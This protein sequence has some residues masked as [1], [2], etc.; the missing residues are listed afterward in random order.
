MAV[1]TENIQIRVD[2]AREAERDLDGVGRAFDGLGGHIA[3]AA[4]GLLTFQTAMKA[5]E[6]AKAGA[7][8]EQVD[9]AFVALGGTAEQAEAAF[10][11]LGG[12]V[13]RDTIKRMANTAKSLGI[14]SDQFTQLTKVALA[15]SKALGRDVKTSLEDIVT[16]TARYS[17]EILD[18]LALKVSVG[19]ANENYARKL[20]KTVGQLSEAEKQQAFF[21]E[22][23]AAGEKLIDRVGD[24]VEGAAGAFSVLSAATDE[25]TGNVSRFLAGLGEDAIAAWVDLVGDAAVSVGLISE[26]TLSALRGVASF[27]KSAVEAA[28]RGSE[29]DAARARANIARLED[30]LGLRNAATESAAALRHQLVEQR[31]A[32]LL[33]SRAF[34]DL[35]DLKRQLP[36]LDRRAAEAAAERQLLAEAEADWQAA[37]ADEAERRARAERAAAAAAKKAAAAAARSAAERRRDARSALDFAVG[38]G[39]R[40][41][42]PALQRDPVAEI[43]KVTERIGAEGARAAERDRSARVEGIGAEIDMTRDLIDIER[44]YREGQLAT[45]GIA[46]MQAAAFARVGTEVDETGI[47]VK[48]FSAILGTTALQAVGA[49]TD[50]MGQWAAQ[51]LLTGDANVKALG[52]SLIAAGSQAIGMGISGLLMAPIVSIFSPGVGAGMAAASAAAIAGGAALAGI[53]KS[54]GGTVRGIDAGGNATGGGASS[55]AAEQ[56]RQRDFRRSRTGEDRETVIVINN[57]IGGERVDRQIHRAAVRGAR[58][59]RPRRAG[60][61]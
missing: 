55:R 47:K 13:D 56:D 30:E 1:T 44:E 20:N 37:A 35:L 29:G 36:A 10:R 9:R 57:S 19:Q 7:Q 27:Q 4:A 6:L 40:D 39:L 51:A 34:K 31:D 33:H 17:K 8:L 58:Y 59:D 45:V 42:V 28:G 5:V 25:A 16:G 32:E 11:S 52:D 15:S 48:S 54:M 23:M 49:M 26:A 50:A 21:N 14:T 38:G 18:N 41:A 2:G 12:T 53:G 46:S 43:D 3:G 22:V 24:G 60:A 61:M